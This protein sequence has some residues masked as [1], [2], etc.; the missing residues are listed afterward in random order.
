[1]A[2]IYSSSK[3]I[4]PRVTIRPLNPVYGVFLEL[5]PVCATRA[6]VE[7]AA[8]PRPKAGRRPPTEDREEAV[9]QL[10]PNVARL[11]RHGD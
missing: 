5:V 4:R 1:M 8:T 7:V 9:H 6:I 11:R 2:D 3:S 10:K